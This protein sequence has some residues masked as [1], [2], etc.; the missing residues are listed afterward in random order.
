MRRRPHPQSAEGWPVAPIAALRAD[1]KSAG[2]ALRLW[3]QADCLTAK[4]MA[5]H[6]N[7]VREMAKGCGSI[8]QRPVAHARGHLAQVAVLRAAN[9]AIVEREDAKAALG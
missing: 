3:Q 8:Q 9:A 1:D 7:V 5:D 2:N 6:Q 4:A